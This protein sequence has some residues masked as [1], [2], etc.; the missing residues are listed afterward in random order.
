MRN[1]MTGVLVVIL[2]ILVT[3]VLLRLIDTN[4][5]MLSTLGDRNE[6]RQLEKSENSK[7]GFIQQLL[8]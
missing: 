1:G 4:G 6:I 2:S 3:I 5:L 7:Q 8:D